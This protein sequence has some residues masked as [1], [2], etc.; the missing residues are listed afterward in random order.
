M[1]GARAQRKFTTLVLTLSAYLFVLAP[2]SRERI[3]GQTVGPVLLTIVLAVGVYTCADR[4]GPFLVAL[5]LA[6]P[7]A[8]LLWAEQGGRS[9]PSAA[10]WVLFALFVVFL[11]VVVS[12]DVLRAVRVTADTI[13]GAVAVYLLLALVWAVAYT[14]LNSLDP[15][16]FQLSVADS[17]RVQSTRAG[18]DMATFVYFSFVTLTT[19]GYGD[20]LPLSH[21]ARGIAT[22]EAVV[23]QVY[24]AVL[25]ARLV[26]MQIAQ[27]ADPGP[28]EPTA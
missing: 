14:I 2:L 6:L 10:V 26:G 24:L 8:T 25:V 16:A 19:M 3:G 18:G 7:A 12:R 5:A 9:E 28:G 1:N 17:A 13:Q 4:R 23:G 11:L 27:G 21:T 20:V 15:G 22:C